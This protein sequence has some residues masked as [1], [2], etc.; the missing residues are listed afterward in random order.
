M[1]L[2]VGIVGMRGIGHTHCEAHTKDELSR[3]VVASVVSKLLK[4]ICR[5]LIGIE[6][7]AD[8]RGAI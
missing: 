6:V 5:D 1:P 8:P 3:F 2:K 4:G 7:L